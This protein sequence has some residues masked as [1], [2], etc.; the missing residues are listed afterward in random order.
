MKFA[1]K[2]KKK[3]IPEWQ[4][5]YI[6]YEL[7][8]SLLKPFKK[9]S[10]LCSKIHDYN[11][12]TLKRQ[13]SFEEIDEDDIEGLKD[14]E[15]KFQ[16]LLYSEIDKMNNFFHMK[17][18]EFKKEWESVKF[19]CL[20][21]IRKTQY[22]NRDKQ[23]GI[24]IKNAIFIFYKKLDFLMEY[25]N[26]NM[27]GVRKVLKKHK[28]ICKIFSKHI[29]ILDTKPQKLFLN[30]Y[31][32]KN[33]DL[34][35]KLK[36]EVKKIYLDMFF[37]R[38][39]K[40]K[41]HKE[42]KDITKTRIISVWESHF[43]F[44]FCGSTITLFLVIL[45][46]GLDGDIDPDD[47]ETF[48]YIFPMFRGAAFIIIYI[49]LLG[50]N[51][52]GWT[53]YHVNY[54]RIFQFNHHFSSV[55]EILKRGTV[56]SSVFFIS[57]IWYM[58]LNENME[59]VSNIVGFIDKSYIPLIIWVLMIVYIFFP[60]PYMFNWEGRKYFFRLMFKIF[61]LSF[62]VLDFTMGWATDQM[63]SFV[64]PIKD[65]EYTICYYISRFKDKDDIHPS[66]CYQNTFVI[67]FLAAFIPVFYRMVQ[68]SRSLLNKRKFFDYDLL[69]FFKY[70]FTLMV[71]IFSYLIGKYKNEQ[72]FVYLW[73]GFALIST[74]YSYSW[75][76][77]MDW[78]LL[79]NNRKNRFL[80]DKLIYPRNQIYYFAIVV[81]L[82][83]RFAW[84]LT[85]SP[86]LVST[87]MRPELFTLI[88]GSLEMLR[89][90]IWN[91]LRVEKEFILNSYN[92]QA[93]EIYVLPYK[94]DENLSFD[95]NIK[96]S[97]GKMSKKYQT[98]ERGENEEEY[99]RNFGL[100]QS[101]DINWPLLKKEDGGLNTEKF[102]LKRK[103]TEELFKSQLVDVIN[104]QDKIN[105]LHKMINEDDKCKKKIEPK[106]E[107]KNE[108]KQEKVSEN[109]INSKKLE[110]EGKNENLLKNSQNLTK[111]ENLVKSTEKLENSDKIKTPNS[112][113]STKSLQDRLV[114]KKS[115]SKPLYS[116]NHDNSQYSLKID[117]H[118]NDKKQDPDT[119]HIDESEK[120]SPDKGHLKELLDQES[121]H[122]I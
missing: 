29:D 50:W 13:V 112:S 55:K 90:A 102:N 93:L 114:V 115:N 64:T 111:S 60:I 121:K 99:R 89:R 53:R 9:T 92:Y 46:M 54:K 43:Y 3:M 110:K 65:L 1:E 88:I 44:F 47:D 14:F 51:A 18:I 10:K 30:S 82:F 35:L 96:L 94:L 116:V 71:A 15:T 75:D 23:E 67:G 74:I 59:N 83:L 66:Q 5:A 101:S 7:L 109:I 61:F 73:I 63:V 104:E 70:F 117:E 37:N 58:I 11:I 28:K 48:K 95:Q 34:L 45:F 38:F 40:N 69:N 103:N 118:N 85:I 97:F 39:N 98:M 27:E 26:L 33:S 36:D 120:N 86:G 84:V 31:I 81:N 62:F 20:I 105:N 56:V 122:I 32:T 87:I 22:H 19:N 57:F 25:M 16:M 76:L 108:E 4:D 113:K 21:F 80:R 119:S 17:L 91:F 107:E 12:K 42:L 24:I 68:C 52:Y 2:L 72:K 8:K 100:F 6:S 49:W 79:Q 78:G 77:K 106:E 41:G